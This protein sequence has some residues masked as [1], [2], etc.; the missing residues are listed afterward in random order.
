MKLPRFKRIN[1][2]DYPEEL[3]DLIEQLSFVL[4][5]GL[6]PLYEALDGRL[7]LSDNGLS[8]IR[9]VQIQVDTAGIPLARTAFSISGSK[10][11]IV[12]G[13]EVIRA[14][15]LLNPIIYP[16]SGVT[17]SFTQE[18][19]LV[20]IDHATGLVPGSTWSLRVVAYG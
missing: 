8:T 5:D 17:L 19:S 9:D 14:V 13:C 11:S 18:G 10:I 6:G 15:N 2:G 12:Q 4:N 1:K 7:S 16:Q 3:R 20:V